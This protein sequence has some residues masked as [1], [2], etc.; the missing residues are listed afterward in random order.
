VG[1]TART[2][3]GNNSLL[4]AQVTTQKPWFGPSYNDTVGD[5]GQDFFTDDSG[6]DWVVFHAWKRGKAGY[7][8]GGER[9][10]RFYPLSDLPPLR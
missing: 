5:G 10:V 4:A 1:L 7:S 3:N 2:S 6:K 9:T 8:H